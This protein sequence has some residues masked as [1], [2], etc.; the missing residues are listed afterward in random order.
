[1]SKKEVTVSYLDHPVEYS[2]EDEDGMENP[3]LT[4]STMISGSQSDFKRLPSSDLEQEEAVGSDE[5]PENSKKKSSLFRRIPYFGFLIIIIKALINNVHNLVVKQLGMH[6]SLIVFFRSFVMF[7]VAIPWTITVDK[8]PFP[9]NTTRML[10]ALFIGRGLLSFLGGTLDIFGMQTL[11]LSIF[12]MINALAPLLVSI[13]ARVFL[14]ES[15]GLPEVVSLIVM[16]TGVICVIK[17]PIF[18]SA[19]L[20]DYDSMF[21]LAI[22]LCCIAV[23]CKAN[24]SVILRFLRHQS[25]ASLTASREIVYLI[26]TFFLIMIVNIPLYNP[27]TEEKLRI[28]GLAC[29]NLVAGTFNM[30]SLKLEEVNQVALVD[31]CFQITFAVLFDY[32]VYSEVPDYISI[33]GITLV[34]ISLFIT[35]GKKIMEKKRMK[36]F[37]ANLR[38]A[39]VEKDDQV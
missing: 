31:R 2:T 35:G 30:V 27:S 26:G 22:G 36:F 4:V 5:Q 13:I 23:F 11:P 34:F 38:T 6:P 28:V 18:F 9:P 10:M 16:L 19:E 15:F 21:W 39:R 33:I 29:C 37:N 1:M 7:S 25:V 14:K 3:E 8:P 24:I 12:Q 20:T 32:L 17:P